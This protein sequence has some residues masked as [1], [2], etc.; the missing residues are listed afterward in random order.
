M[1]DLS[2]QIPAGN[3]P[4][5]IEH[6]PV[7]KNVV[8]SQVKRFK[9]KDYVRIFYNGALT[10]VVNRRIGCKLYQV[11]LISSLLLCMTAHLTIGFQVYTMEK[12]KRKLC[13]YDDKRYLLADLPDVRPNSNTHAYGHRYLVAEEHLVADKP[14]T[15]AK[16]IIRHPE[17]R[18]ARRHARVT[19]GLELAGEL[20]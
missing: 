8:R 5:E 17:K 7:A 19:R 10:N 12:K 18:F 4:M 14:E 1:C 6:K 11:R 13:H 3:S 16:L 2:E 20:R 9:H 15:G